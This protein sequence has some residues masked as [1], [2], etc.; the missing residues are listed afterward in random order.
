[1]STKKG[2]Q[3]IG[4]RP[5]ITGAGVAI[6]S[7]A[8]SKE[9]QKRSLR[10]LEIVHNFPPFSYA[11]TELYTLNLA[12][13]LQTLGHDVTIL[14][15]VVS[16]EARSYSFENAIYEGIKVTR[17]NIYDGKALIRS[18]FF[19]PSYD[20]PFSRYLSSHN[21]DIVHFQHLYSLSANWITIAKAHGCPVFLKI[22]DMFMYCAQIHLVQNQKTYCSGPESL[23]KCAECVF[24]L[25]ENPTREEITQAHDHLVFRKAQLQKKFREA[26]LV[27]SP[28]AFLKDACLNNDFFN[29][30]FHVIPTGISPFKV[31]PRRKESKQDGSLRVAFLGHLDHRK[32]VVDFLQAIEL[33]ERE[34]ENSKRAMTLGFDIYGHHY[35]DELYHYTLSKTRQL[36]DTKYKGSFK[37]E[38]RPNVF[39]KIDLLVMPSIGENYPFILRE[40]MYAGVP[41]VATEIAGVPEIIQDNKNGFLYPPGNVKAL[42]TIFIKLSTEPSVLQQLDT[43]AQ[44]IKTIDTEAKEIESEFR[45]LLDQN[46]SN[47]EFCLSARSEKTT[48][49]QSEESA[50]IERLFKKSSLL[51]KEG[52]YIE[53]SSVL[54]E[55]L[56]LDPKHFDS[57]LLL[58][59]LYNKLGKPAQ[60]NQLWEIAQSIQPYDLG[61]LK[62][63]GIAVD[64]SIIIPVFNQIEFT[65]RCL[66]SIQKNTFQDCYEII[67]ADNN[68]T[69]GTG[70][71]LQNSGSVRVIQNSEN[72]GFSI[73]CNQGAEAA[74]HEFI[75][76]LNNDME[77]LQG[78]LQPMIAILLED[79]EVGVVGSKLL[80]PDG[81]IQHA[82]VITV[83]DVE[84]SKPLDPWH[85]YYRL[86][87][88]LPQANIAREYPAV[89]GACLLTR[90]SLFQELGGF[91]P[92][93]R[94]GFEDVDYCYKVGAAGY[95]I[96]YEPK[97]VVIHYESQSGPERFADNA[98]NFDMLVSRWQDKVPPDVRR[99]GTGHHETL[100]PYKT[101]ERE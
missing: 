40:A 44:T 90:R 68:S 91:D 38:D 52:N 32:G 25:N 97:S 54:S 58:G 94:N 28:S 4:I 8:H 65:K 47:K 18:D 55:I 99:W 72:L 35:N 81:T 24:G 33:Y 48:A 85:I 30:E 70:E 22:D 50:R 60:A 87:G 26:D 63:L 41:V 15:P 89:T 53:G 29:H 9:E 37:P 75:L 96:V 98:P 2:A 21:F 76:F 92:V 71:F 11:G 45:R 12:K 77:V 95:K 93:F 16:K 7:H 56:K 14:H 62:R 10:I 64:C 73:A 13:E 82:G 84:N 31:E 101:Y 6:A 59:D 61:L 20:E 78:W 3:E 27:H 36:K 39:S 88:S 69:D 43:Q 67:L 83:D 79:P 42:A 5:N 80:Y 19:N 46:D 100:R 86:D 74:S 49:S 34:L 1:M 51:V 57:I 17:F 66:E 23:Q